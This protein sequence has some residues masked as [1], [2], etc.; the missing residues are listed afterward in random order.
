MMNLF[1]ALFIIIGIYM[2]QGEVALPPAAIIEEVLPDT[3]AQAAGFMAGDQIL[4]I[5]FA[6]GT[7]L[8]PDNFYDVVEALQTHTD[9]ATYTMLRAGSE[10]KLSVTPL[11]LESENRYILGI[12]IPKADM[13]KITPFEAIGY[14]VVEAK[15]ILVSMVFAIGNLL[16][17]IGLESLSGPI[18]IFQVTQEQASLGFD[19]L[20]FLTGIL[21]LN[22]AVFNLLPLPIMDGGRV[23]LIIYEMIFKK[24][25]NQKVEQTLMLVSASILILL[26]VLVTF[27]D[28]LR[29][30]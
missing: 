28:I 3:P 26:M 21:S 30:F 18:G 15:D 23:V 17:G 19:N 7:T 25:I 16:R 20:I 8:I 9:T 10:V 12:N 13:K 6:D 27:N 29:L 2:V 4:Q 24:P 14:G 1:L 5:D 22:V 11:F